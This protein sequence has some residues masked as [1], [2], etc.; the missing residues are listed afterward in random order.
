MPNQQSSDA[1]LPKSLAL[2]AILI[3]GLLSL[4]LGSCAQKTNPER[5]AK[6]PL[7]PPVA[8]EHRDPLEI[9]FALSGG[10]KPESNKAVG[11]KLVI[12]N[13]GNKSFDL[14]FASAQEHDFLVKNDD[15]KIV[16][17]WSNGKFFAQSIVAKTL[18]SGSKMEIESTWNK[19][20]NNGKL[21]PPGKYKAWARLN[22]IGKSK[23]VGPLSI[24]IV[25]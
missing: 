6:R 7:A 8:I 5:P 12:R 20:S 2:V 22:T 3:L 24:N 11:L 10:W 23:L 25:K 21:L 1:P 4:A 13:T 15:G 18:N 9:V 19:K 16:W 17:Q 14:E